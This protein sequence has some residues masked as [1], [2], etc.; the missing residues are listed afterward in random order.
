MRCCSLNGNGK[1]EVGVHKLSG[2][3]CA[4]AGGSSCSELFITNM[5]AFVRHRDS[6]EIL[7]PPVFSPFRPNLVDD[8]HDFSMDMT[9]GKKDFS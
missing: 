1:K 2:K 6:I 7:F 8:L 5:N 4:P 3:K 9:P